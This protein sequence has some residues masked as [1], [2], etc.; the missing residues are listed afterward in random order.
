[1][2][3][4]KE[5]QTNL[6]VFNSLKA[7]PLASITLLAIASFGCSSPLVELYANFSLLEG[8]YPTTQTLQI[9]LPPTATN[10]Y[11][12]TNSIDPVPNAAC[13]YSGEDLTIDR[14]TIVKLIYNVGGDK[15][16]YEKQYR[17][18]ENKVDNRFTNRNVIETWEYFFK[19]HVLSQFSPSETENSFLTAED[20]EGGTATVLTQYSHHWL[21]NDIT[22]GSQTYTFNFFEKTDAETGE[23]VMLRSGILSGSQGADGGYYM[24]DDQAPITFS[25][26]YHGWAEGAF[27]TNAEGLTTDGYY[28]VYCTDAGCAPAPVVY[29]LNPSH[30]FIEIDQ[31]RSEFTHSC[32][33]VVQNNE[34]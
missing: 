30:G 3:T 34:E 8:V 7:S 28:K 14:P 11:L 23:V 26:T 24:T 1:M 10:V 25:G 6:K 21:T 16:S 12:T 20:G 9:T 31:K 5:N 32:E 17:V 33:E 29:Y 27:F 22:G 4:D 15:F 13:A 2:I 19:K 18:E